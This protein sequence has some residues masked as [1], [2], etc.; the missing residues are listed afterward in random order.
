MTLIHVQRMEDPFVRFNK[1]IV[2]DKRISWK[3][4]GILSYAFSRPDNW[5]FY[6]SE[7]ME[8]ATDGRESLESGL[9][10]LRLCG[11]LH[12]LVKR[13]HETGKLEGQEWYFFEKPLSDDDFQKMFPK[14]GFPVTRKT[15]H[16]EDPQLLR[17]TSSKKDIQ[18]K[19]TTSKLVDPIKPVKP[20]AT[21]VVFSSINN[22]NLSNDQKQKISFKCKDEVFANKL[23]ERVLAW[24]DRKSD[25]IACYTILR[26]WDSWTD[27]K[28]EKDVEEE[29]TELLKY[30]RKTKDGR[31]SSK[32]GY[33]IMVGS[34]GVSFVSTAPDPLKENF[35]IKV[36]DKKFKEK[37]KNLYDKYFK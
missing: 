20:S 19:T 5:S 27:H 21:V 12:T 16:T 26:D 15:C 4:K 32:T 8:H 9:K 2:Y 6:K 10:E 23:V 25:E 11:Y 17:K 29:N 24:K 36:T 18:R 33:K 22:L 28:D 3:A 34:S 13:N 1:A 37:L 31:V 35:E 14:Q 7:M 30:F